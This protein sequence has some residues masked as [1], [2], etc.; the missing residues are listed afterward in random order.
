[1]TDRLLDATEVAERLGV[2]ISWVRESARS[3]AMPCVRLGRYVR[4]DLAD[5]EAWIQSCKQPGRSIRLR[6]HDAAN[7]AQGGHDEAHYGAT[8]E[9]EVHRRPTGWRGRR[10]HPDSAGLGV[11][12]DRIAHFTV[13]HVGDE[14]HLHTVGCV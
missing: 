5:V 3:G 10:S 11:D 2:P 12:G 13:E 4:F 7:A 14:L 1:M 8:T 9:T 6:A